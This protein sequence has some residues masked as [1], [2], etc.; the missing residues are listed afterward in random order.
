MTNSTA[1]DLLRHLVASGVQISL[2]DTVHLDP[3]IP[4]ERISTQ[5]VAIHPGCRISGAE[6]YIAQGAVI[7]AEGPVTIHNCQVGPGVHL[8][9]GYFKEAVFLEGASMGLG[10]H[11]REG[12]ILEEDASGAHTVGLKQTILFPH[13]TLGSLINFCD[14]LMAGGSDRKNHSEV[15]SSYIHFN[16][17]PNQD[18]ATPSLLGDVP[19]GVMLDQPPIFLGGQGGLVGPCRLAF[20][21]VTAAGTICRNDELRP[22]HLIFGGASR[23]GSIP[24]SPGPA[25]GVGRIVGHNVFFM[26]NLVALYQWYRHVRALFVSP[27]FP[28]PLQAGLLHKVR[29][30]LG[31]RLKRLQDFERRLDAPHFGDRWTRVESIFSAPERD[32]GSTQDRDHFLGAVTRAVAHQGPDYIGVIKGLGVVDRETGRRWLQ[33]IVQKVVGELAP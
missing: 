28:Q 13:V 15:G 23:G 22:S 32:Q 18:K 26:A 7:G 3:R 31:E 27:R 16:F 8:K 1:S 19:N 29:L 10:A 11:V 20:G 17:T 4:L 30:A 21:T 24:W 5:G 14:V 33:G 12:T 25:S 2:P 9:G 6:T